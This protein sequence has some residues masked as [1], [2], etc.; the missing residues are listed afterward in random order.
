[1]RVKIPLERIGVLVGSNGRVKRTIESKTDLK[2]EVN[3]KIGDVELTL[4]SKESDPSMIY[5]ARDIV[6]AIG[7]GFSP[8]NAFKLFDEEMYFGIIDLRDYLGK[9][10]ANIER[11]KGR[12]IGRNGKTRKIIEE[13]TGTSIS[14]Y[15]HTVSIIGELEPF[16][17]AKDAVELL[18][19]GSLHKSVYRFLQWKWSDLQKS[20]MEIWK[21]SASELAK[22]EA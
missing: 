11:I 5:R 19:K 10:Q 2:V 18:I 20:K 14:I 22:E 4:A 16:E 13:L 17:V 9:S 15:G 8:E 3:S 1:M 21:L 6:L 7:R 12:I